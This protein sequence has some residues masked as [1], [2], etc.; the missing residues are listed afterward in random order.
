M[1]RLVVLTFLIAC[2][3]RPAP[4]PAPPP[5]RPS[6][7]LALV[8]ATADLDGARIGPLGTGRATVLVV[9]ASWCPHCQVELDVLG[10]LRA[11]HTGV[12]ILGVNYVGHEEYK[13]RGNALAVRAYLAEHAPWLRVVPADDEL[14]AALGR[15]PKIPTIYIYDRTG[16]LA[17]KFDRRERPQPTAAELEE[18]LARLTEDRSSPRRSSLAP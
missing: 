6:G 7:P 8:E 10:E 16:A 2:A 17:A 1:V 18:I 13:G 14:F 12:R 11:R 4:A 5:P 9:F 15:P 3:P